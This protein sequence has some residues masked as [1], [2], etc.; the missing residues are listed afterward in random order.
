[1]LFAALLLGCA[2]VPGP[3]G[4]LDDLLRN[5]TFVLIPSPIALSFG[6]IN[7][8]L[9]TT[10]CAGVAVDGLG[11]AV[12]E[13]PPPPPPSQR[14]AAARGDGGA[15]LLMGVVGLAASGITIDCNADLEYVDAD[16][17]ETVSIDVDIAIGKSSFDATL[18]F[19]A[20]PDA[21]QPGA[22][23]LPT[24][25]N[26]TACASSWTIDDVA[27]TGDSPLISL[28]NALKPVIEAT[29]TTAL[30]D[31]LCPGIRALT[32]SV[33]DPLLRN[34][35]SA[36]RPVVDSEPP[37]FEA[38]PIPRDSVPLPPSLIN[39]AATLLDWRTS[40]VLALVDFAVDDVLGGDPRRDPSGL[41]HGMDLI[42]PLL[43]HLFPR[44]NGSV[45][46]RDLA[47]P[48]IGKA[49]ALLNL[50]VA[51]HALRVDGLETLSTLDVVEPYNCGVL[52]HDNR[53]TGSGDLPY[54]TWTRFGADELNVS[55][56]LGLT[57]G[58]GSAVLGAAVGE[59]TST[60]EIELG[61]DAL[62]ATAIAMAAVDGAALR[63]LKLGSLLSTPIACLL[64]L[65]TKGDVGLDFTGL[66]LRSNA[67]HGP[68]ISG[69]IST[70]LDAL[71]ASAI[72]AL[73]V[74]YG[75]ALSTAVRSVSDGPVRSFLNSI[76]QLVRSFL[77][78]ILPTC[79]G[80]TAPPAPPSA[81]PI[82]SFADSP[83]LDLLS[84]SISGG[85]SAIGV[86]GWLVDIND[87]VVRS[88]PAL[89]LR[90]ENI[91]LIGAGWTA[92]KPNTNTNTRSAAAAAPINSFSTV[93]LTAAHPVPAVALTHEGAAF[94]IN[95]KNPL[96][97]IVRIAIGNVTLSGIDSFQNLSIF[98][99]PPAI[100]VSSDVDANYTLGNVLTIGSKE[101][102]LALSVAISVF[103]DGAGGVNEGIEIDDV[104]IIELAADQ[105]ALDVPL[106]LKL[107]RDNMRNLTMSTLFLADILSGKMPLA[108]ALTA[109]EQLELRALNASLTNATITMRCGGAAGCSSPLLR[110][111][112][113]EAYLRR[114]SIG[115]ALTGILDGTLGSGV[116]IAGVNK[117]LVETIAGASDRCSRGGVKPPPA[118]SSGLSA[119]G[120]GVAVGVGI[121]GGGLLIL[122]I[123]SAA[124][125]HTYR[126]L[127]AQSAKK[128]RAGWLGTSKPKGELRA[129][130]SSLAEPLLDS[131][132]SATIAGSDGAAVV[133]PPAAARRQRVKEMCGCNASGVRA[134]SLVCHHAVPWWLRAVMP[135]VLCVAIVIF[136]TNNLSV[137]ASIDVRIAFAGDEAIKL[138]PLFA[139]SL[140]N[141]VHDMWAA[142]V[143]VLALLI[144]IFSGGWPYLKILLMLAAWL[145]PFSNESLY[146]AP[147]T[148]ERLLGWLDALGK[149]SLI[150][151]YLMILFTCAFRFHIAETYV[152]P[153]TDGDVA[154][155]LVAD[156]FVHPHWGLHGFLIATI[157]SLICS[158]IIVA[159]QRAVDA[160]DAER[161]ELE[162]EALEAMSSSSSSYCKEAVLPIDSQPSDGCIP[163]AETLSSS[164]AS[165]GDGT[166]VPAAGTS[167]T[168]RVALRNIACGC[169]T[170]WNTSDGFTR[171]GIVRCDRIGQV[172]LMACLIL[173]LLL[174]TVGIS[175]DSFGFGFGG[176][177]GLALGESAE[178][179]YSVLSLVG[180]LS[181]N[182][183]EVHDGMWFVICVSCCLL[184]IVIALIIS[185]PA[186]IRRRSTMPVPPPPTF[187]PP[188]S[189]SS[190]SSSTTNNNNTPPPLLLARSTSSSHY[191]CRSFSSYFSRSSGSYQCRSSGS[192]DS[193]PP[194]SASTHGAPLT[195]SPSLSSQ[196]SSKLNNSS[197]SSSA[198]N[199]IPS[200]PY[201]A[202]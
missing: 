71:L 181:K 126:R 40:P 16:T 110:D 152:E 131:A 64:P 190:S 166:L 85:D 50:S 41:G 160:A 188:S 161:D 102:P 184:S 26:L 172:L 148:R 14:G 57:L 153:G 65:L 202:P 11:I 114:S 151:A 105:L 45:D 82:V 113:I 60:V 182:D 196:P 79:P 61:L 98:V 19:L 158:H 2:T 88:L 100:S 86:D 15:A 101:N 103:F 77:P 197:R 33:I 163:L 47:L 111:G 183:P 39:N 54:S 69:V 157:V 109:V 48:L 51:L 24:A 132:A 89:L 74:L 169:K 29:L 133:L 149:W 21:I 36:L 73:K 120:V 37:P 68:R 186:Y 177:A 93:E 198:V 118:S 137:G 9:N 159:A 53:T 78:I 90:L 31:L 156:L 20:S 125:L 165:T 194:R 95:S 191:L 104:I 173:A 174:F 28:L 22:A 117:L 167:A 58:P 180:F 17:R 136:A 108:C 135:L 59:Y 189:S 147:A 44:G 155:W 1:M 145:L 32:T 52:P 3:F 30:D 87:L 75:G 200:T 70:G 162:R 63:E 56:E 178:A 142:R 7:V 116:L 12:M 127:K 175:I 42:E 6:G 201:F 67:M 112:S 192:S 134:R 83:V 5:L 179:H 123:G 76:V 141:S 139:F 91:D 96:Y 23:P 115:K 66:E 140:A 8:T 122:L 27:F 171:V 129:I 80:A 187:P 146:L 150:D 170:R 38:T 46:L 124:V 94:A 193:S 185:L 154:Q 168:A 81:T 62:D 107:V 176:L 119:E 55:I 106:L 143:Y 92:L 195:S 97:G 164:A 99:P 18:A 84:G 25:V 35:S 199:V 138:P 144:A 72:E 49:G 43:A 121:I 4:P 128:E 10:T 130:S 34:V 13:P